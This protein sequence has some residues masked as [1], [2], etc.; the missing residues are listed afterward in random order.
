MTILPK[1]SVVDYINVGLAGESVTV[2][3]WQQDDGEF[4]ILENMTPERARWFGRALLHVADC[5]ERSVFS[6]QVTP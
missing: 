6:G 5:A 2:R 4:E 1:P 3:R